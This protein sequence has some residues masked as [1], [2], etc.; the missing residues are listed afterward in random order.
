[1]LQTYLVA[2]LVFF[3]I[4]TLLILIHELGHFLTA[5]FFN[6]KVEEFGLG[7]PPRLFGVKKGETLYSLNAIPAGGFVKLAGEDAEEDSKDPRSFINKSPWQRAVIIFAGVIMNF[8]L[9]LVAFTILYMAGGPV[10]SGK[11]LIVDVA[12][13][14]PAEEAGIKPND[15][16]VEVAGQKIAGLDDLNKRIKENAGKKV[17]IKLEREKNQFETQLTPRVSPPANQGPTGIAISNYVETKAYPIWEAPIV[18]TQQ[19]V[20]IT[21]LMLDGFKNM[22]VNLAAKREVPQD[23]GGVV[24]IGYITYIATQAGILPLIQ[25]TGLL[26]LNL[27]LINALPIPALDGGRLFFTL[28]EAITRKRVPLKFEKWVH[29]VGF[30]L[31]LGLIAMITFSDLTFLLDNTKLGEK[32]RD[33]LPF[34]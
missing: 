11:V 18:G 21:G 31:L 19:A 9:A 8:L 27:A 7:L 32:L 20:K 34:I 23:V 25:W 28:V 3:V 26:S 12:K 4:L 5:K 10:D 33:L 14:S 22:I 2:G 17:S 1:M 30:A 15:I 24:K 29:M 13:D 16:V 6:V